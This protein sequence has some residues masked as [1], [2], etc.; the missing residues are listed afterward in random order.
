[1][2]FADNTFP[3]RGKKD[4]KLILRVPNGTADAFKNDKR[5]RRF[6][7]VENSIQCTLEGTFFTEKDVL[8]MEHSEYWETL[9]QS[10]Q[11][12]KGAHMF[13]GGTKLRLTKKMLKTSKDVELFVNGKRAKLPAIITLLAPTTITL[14]LKAKGGASEGSNDDNTDDEGAGN[15]NSSD[16]DNNNSPDNSNPTAITEA[17]ALH[18]LVYPNPTTDFL[19]VSDSLPVEAR[20][21]LVSLTGDVLQQGYLPPSKVLDVQAF[22]AGVYIL[23]IIV[24]NQNYT[25][26]F[27][28]R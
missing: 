8:S 28:K 16:N 27:L 10:K 22:P 1:M 6:T 23:N 17:L 25:T 14:N 26:R 24:G 3:S 21:Q 11:F 5:Y 12:N 2:T 19:R 20:Y 7:I 9:R 13:L 15:G 4:K 18:K